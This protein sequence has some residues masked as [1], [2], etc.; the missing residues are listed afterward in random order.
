M[1]KL[2]KTSYLVDDFKVALF[3]NVKCFGFCIKL[4]SWN[5]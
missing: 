4:S 3:A 5:L 1:Y 2:E